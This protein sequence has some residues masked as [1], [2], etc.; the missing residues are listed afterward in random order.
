M[1]LQR[2]KTREYNSKTYYR[3]RVDISEEKLKEAKFKE[4]DELEAE[5]KEG[6]IKLRKSRVN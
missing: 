4:G 1:K 3:Y 6:E 5:A 2:I